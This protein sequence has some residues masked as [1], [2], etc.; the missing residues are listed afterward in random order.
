MKN[1]ITHENIF[2]FRSKSTDLIIKK[3][4]AL[5]LLEDLLTLYIH[6]R[7]FTFEKKNRYKVLKSSNPG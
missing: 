7:T 5:T 2:K 4:I 6:V 1:P 3:E